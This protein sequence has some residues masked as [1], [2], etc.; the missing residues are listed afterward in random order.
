MK[1][2]L[3]LF[4]ILMSVTLTMAQTGSAQDSSTQVN[5]TDKKPDRMV[6]YMECIRVKSMDAE[7]GFMGCGVIMPV[8]RLE[9]ITTIEY[10]QLESLP[11]RNINAIAG[12]VP[13]V[14][15]RNGQI[16][17][18]RGAQQ[19]GTAYYIDGIR[20]MELDISI[21]NVK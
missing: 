19:S 17:N 4:L 5:I 1:S 10:R 14:D 3:V 12:T 8:A 20:T 13:G 2:I 11:Q 6:Y 21:G 15:S 16:P 9:G 18:I 7:S